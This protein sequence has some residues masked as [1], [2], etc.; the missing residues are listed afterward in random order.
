MEAVFFLNRFRKGADQDVYEKWVREVDYPTCKKYFRSIVS[1]TAFKVKAESMKESPY[2][3]VEYIGLTS[4]EDY[5]RDMQK[6]EMKK[7]LEEWSRYIESA[8][9]VFADSI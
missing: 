5:E 8:I 7:L 2:D 4:K 3:Y 9:V 1:Y 6:P